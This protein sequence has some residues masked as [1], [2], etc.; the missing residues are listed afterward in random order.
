MKRFIKFIIK[1][2]IPVSLREKIKYLLNLRCHI[3]HLENLIQEFMGRNIVK[4]GIEPFCD[5]LP[6]FQLVNTGFFDNNKE[7]AEYYKSQY[8]LLDY[9]IEFLN[10]L[11]RL[12]N[13]EGFRVIEIGGSNIPREMVLND[14]KVKQWVCIDKPYASTVARQ[15]RHYDSITMLKLSPGGGASLS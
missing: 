3:E 13:L 6:L 9:H 11:T 12:F 2:F 4:D 10:H 5:Q 14:F 1:I 7:K 8:G 15:K